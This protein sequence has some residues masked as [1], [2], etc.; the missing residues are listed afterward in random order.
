MKNNKTNLEKQIKKRTKCNPP[1]LKEFFE[2]VLPNYIKKLKN[3]DMISIADRVFSEFVR[4]V[5]ATDE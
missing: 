5:H 4:L 3:I 2:D 1:H